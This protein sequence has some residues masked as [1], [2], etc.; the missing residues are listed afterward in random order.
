MSRV[1]R[2]REILQDSSIL[3]RDLLRAYHTKKEFI[4]FDISGFNAGTICNII[5]TNSYKR[6][7]KIEKGL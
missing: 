7:L 2:V 6:L 4:V 1:N 3:T 5:C